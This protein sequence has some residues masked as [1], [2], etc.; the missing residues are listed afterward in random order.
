[1]A[2]T[3]PPVDDGGGECKGAQTEWG[4][5][6]SC[7][8]VDDGTSSRCPSSCFFAAIALAFVGSPT[9]SAADETPAGAT[10]AA[11]S[12]IAEE[13][14][15]SPQV[16][17]SRLEFQVRFG[18]VVNHI[19]AEV[20]SYVDS[21]LSDDFAENAGTVLLAD[22]TEVEW[23]PRR[24]WIAPLG[25]AVELKQARLTAAEEQKR[26]DTARDRLARLDD[27][28]RSLA[29]GWAADI[30]R[31]TVV[32][33]GSS[34]KLGQPERE[35]IQSDLGDLAST[36]TVLD[37]PEDFDEDCPTDPTRTG[38]AP[39]GGRMITAMR[40]QRTLAQIIIRPFAFTS[41]IDRHT[42]CTRTPTVSVANNRRLV[43]LSVAP[44]GTTP[45]GTVRYRIPRGL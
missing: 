22:A 31:L 9:V 41:S 20:P 4:R 40:E 29:L 15:V 34:A 33:F 16:A 36:V 1:M 3:C 44:N 19:A 13:F 42:H 28:G 2:R 21:A 5:S 38:G 35:L 17:L 27:S 8:P 39:E 23:Q 26:F 18:E 30:D 14:G 6:W 32:V 24:R 37:G 43:V 25:D 11:V 45:Y 7:Q 10:D 12:A